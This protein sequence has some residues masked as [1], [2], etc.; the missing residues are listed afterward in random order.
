MSSESTVNNH[1][2]YIHEEEIDFFERFVRV[3]NIDWPKDQKENLVLAISKSLV[4][5][6]VTPLRKINLSPKYKEIGFEHIFRMYLYV[7]GYQS[8]DSSHVLDVTSSSKSIDVIE[9]FLNHLIKNIKIGIIQEY[10]ETN[11]ITTTIKG[12]VQYTQTYVN[13]L[14][15]KR[16]PVVTKVHRLSLN[17]KINYLIVA[18]LLKIRHIKNYSSKANELLMY[19]KNVNPNILS[20]KEALKNIIFNTNTIRYQQT[21]VYASMIIDQMD[22]DD[23]GNTVGTESFI[24][25]FDKLFEDFV[26]K[27]LKEQPKERN[28]TVWNYPKKFAEVSLWGAVKGS[29]HY[30]PDILYKF[31]AEDEQYAYK[32]SAYGVLDVKN[33]AYSQFK[34]ADIYQILVYSSLLYAKKAILIYPSFSI[35]YPEKLVL[36]PDLFSPHTITGVFINIAS[37]SGDEFLQDIKWFVELVEKVLL[38]ID[39]R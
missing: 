11:T 24:L 21:L 23:L 15:C 12:K 34:N 8:T 20:G 27:I 28:F 13:S 35:R 17:N 22:Y 19:F 26:V 25:N 33:K 2:I 16:K 30:L 9:M 38:D 7:Y 5:Y 31:N 6:I 10:I 4:G 29:R 3:H 36:D 18:A 14:C 37:S 39:Y 1:L 32:A